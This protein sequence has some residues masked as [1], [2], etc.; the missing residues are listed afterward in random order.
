ME[1]NDPYVYPGT[2][3]LINKLGIKDADKLQE[4][5]RGFYL[6]KSYEPLPKGNFDYT[7][8]KAIHKHFL[9]DIYEW[10]GKERT[11]DIAKGNSY[12]AH[13]AYIASAITKQF[14]KLKKDNYLKN[15]D[16]EIFTEK[17]ASYFNELN[18]AHP[19]REGNGRTLRAF[20]DLLSDKAGYKLTWSNV[21]EK[22]Y[23][24]ASIKGF[25]GHDEA[26]KKVFDKIAEPLGQPINQK[27]SILS[28]AVKK[29]LT[30]YVQSLNN[31]EQLAEQ[32]V[33]NFD[34]PDEDKHVTMARE[35]KEDY[36]QKAQGIIK[37]KTIYEE[38]QKNAKFSLSDF[39]EVGGLKAIIDRL[40]NNQTTTEDIGLINNHVKQTINALCKS[41][42]LGKGKG[43]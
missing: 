22:E 23:I 18:A 32:A 5:E 28:E 39:N 29:I 25:E 42:T 9:G 8:L 37:N 30:E 1:Q 24:D 33:K 12:F 36:Q 11:I 16:K 19:F 15:L 35:A 21:N 3:I 13:N 10:A 7:H 43:R 34:T 2:E 4:V 17:A 41:Q 20:F 27:Q 6:E 40:K 14:D 31:Y 26:M 38:L